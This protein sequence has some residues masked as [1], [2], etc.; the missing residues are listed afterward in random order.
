V[1]VPERSGDLILHTDEGLFTLTPKPGCLVFFPPDMPHEVSKN[2]AD[3]F[4][5]S[6]GMNFGPQKN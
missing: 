3:A 1:T 2:C 5:L 4:R 6:V